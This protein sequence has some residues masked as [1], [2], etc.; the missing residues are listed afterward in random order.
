[1]KKVIILFVLVISCLYTYISQAQVGI[2]T[3]VPNSSAMLDINS[4]NRGLLIPQIALTGTTDTATITSPAVSLLVYNTAS[5]SDVTPGYYYNSGTTSSPVWSKFA[6]ATG[7]TSFNHYIGELFGGGIIVAVWKEGGVEHG[8]IASLVNLSTIKKPWTTASYYYNSEVPGGALSPIDGLSNSNAIVAEAGADTTY[9]AG[10]CRA[11]S[12]AGDGGLYDWCLPAAWELTQCYNAALIVNNVL[13]ATNGFSFDYYWS[14]TETG[15][16]YA[17]Y[18]F[19]GNGY[20]DYTG[21]DGV[22]TVR[23]VRRF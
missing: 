13:G 18:L 2:G 15:T 14:S 1:M 4:T 23:A 10:L 9:A 12:A 6:T 20:T 11:Y 7:N 5:T 21:K 22:T 3:T 16:G 19:F 8:L 17:W